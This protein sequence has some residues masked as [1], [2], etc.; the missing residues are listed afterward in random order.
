MIEHTDD[1]TLTSDQ[2]T[3]DSTMEPTASGPDACIWVSDSLLD[4]EEGTK[5]GGPW[6]AMFVARC[7]YDQ[8]P[9][10]ISNRKL[11][12]RCGRQRDIDDASKAGLI[13]KTKQGRWKLT[14]RARTLILP[15]PPGQ[16]G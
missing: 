9:E 13:R 4:G 3:F 8:Q 7:E 2:I 16:P 14:K 6:A 12:A 1:N 15:H 10:G 11:R 5:G